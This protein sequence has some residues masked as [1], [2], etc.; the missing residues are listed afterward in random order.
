M[1]AMPITGGRPFRA[2]QRSLVRLH[3]D[4]QTVRWHERVDTWPIFVVEHGRFALRFVRSP[5]GRHV[6]EG[7]AKVSERVLI[8]HAAA[9][10]PA[11]IGP[12]SEVVQ[13]SGPP[14]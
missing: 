14:P 11:C 4:G 8:D 1:R 10:Y 3:T 7:P 13:F 6:T 12:D 5:G 9:E 2:G